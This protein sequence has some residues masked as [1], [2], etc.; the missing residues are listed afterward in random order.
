MAGVSKQGTCQQPVACMSAEPDHVI[1][2]TTASVAVPPVTA[3]RGRAPDLLRRLRGAPAPARVGPI[4][5]E[6]T[7]EHL[8]LVQFDGSGERPR[9]RALAV[10]PLPLEREALLADPRRFTRLL[11]EARA[12]G[13]FKGRATVSCL[14]PT[15][16]KLSLVS[17][18]LKG[19]E[20]DAEAVMAVAHERFGAEVAD[21]VIDFLPVRTR[22]EGEGDRAALL[23]AAP[24][25]DVLD[26][27]EVLRGAG[28]QVSALDVGPAAVARAVAA[29][30]H[31]DD[32]DNVL[33][34]NFARDSSYLTVFS[35]RR[36]ILDREVSLGQSSLVGAVANGLDTSDSEALELLNL[37]GVR[38]GAAS[39]AAWA[40]DADD[41]QIAGTLTDI[42]RPRMLELRDELGKAALYAASHTRGAGIREVL[43]LGGVARWP[44][45]AGLLGGVL[46]LPV[47]IM[48]PLSAL[49]LREG[50]CLPADAG[51]LSG[52]TNATGC[53]LR[54]LGRGVDDRA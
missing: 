34:V 27:L 50:V 37:Y 48:D 3:E 36:L 35:G 38:A 41:E 32:D 8:N 4:G 39:G 33:T 22:G 18:R 21:L 5:L 2:P 1:E 23:A 16:L 19:E 7:Q 54:G 52:L 47:A 44:H 17:Y 49:P 43:L 30:H 31:G 9:L 51:L 29:I 14:P 15:L 24:R 53:A 11:R 12:L 28:L 13:G 40:G 42:L 25:G 45:I 20:S 6:V 46:D 10:L 26:Y